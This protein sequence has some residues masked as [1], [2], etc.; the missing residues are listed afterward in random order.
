[1]DFSNVILHKLLQIIKSVKHDLLNDFS[2]E[3]KKLYGTQFLTSIICLSPS[4]ILIK[5]RM[6]KVVAVFVQF[7]NLFFFFSIKKFALKLD[8][9]LSE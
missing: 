1:M 6:K 5:L 8:Y 2:Y 9:I 7:I 3:K 4:Q